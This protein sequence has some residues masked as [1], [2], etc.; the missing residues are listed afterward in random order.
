M[1]LYNKLVR[2]LI[3]DV[4]ERAGHRCEIRVLDPAGR[5]TPL[6]HKLAEEVAEYRSPGDPAELA[7]VLEVVRA[8]GAADGP[9]RPPSKPSAPPGPPIGVASR[10]ASSWSA[11]SLAYFAVRNGAS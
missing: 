3:P 6:Q 9:T 2:D 7:D 11:R 1:P 10:R 8:L 5:R 4:I